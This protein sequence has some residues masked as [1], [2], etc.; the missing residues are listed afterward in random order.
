MKLSLLLI[1]LVA[2]LAAA[3]SDRITT[4]TDMVFDLDPSPSGNESPPDDET[5]TSIQQN[6]FDISCAL[7]GCH[8]GSVFPDLSAGKAYANIVDAPSSQGLPLIAPEDP[9][10]SYLYIKITAGSGMQDSRMPFGRSP[11]PAATLDAVKN[12]IERGAPDD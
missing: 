7:S 3:C 8:R 2:L 10:G 4:S 6:V 1:P 11:L 9:D 12:W 5:F